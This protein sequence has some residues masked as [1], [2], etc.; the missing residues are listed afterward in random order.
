MSANRTKHAF[1]RRPLLDSTN[2]NYPAPNLAEPMSALGREQPFAV[3]P[4]ERQDS[5]AQSSAA[6]VAS[7]SRTDF[8]YLD[9]RNVKFRATNL[10]M[11]Q[12]VV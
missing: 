7:G 12:E 11:S 10:V 2:V 9:D 1:T 8:R 3:D 4:R 6:H 5:G